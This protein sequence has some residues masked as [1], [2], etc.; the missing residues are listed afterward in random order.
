MNAIKDMY[1][2]DMTSEVKAN[3]PNLSLVKSDEAKKD[4]QLIDGRWI[5][6]EELN[7][8][9]AYFYENGGPVMDI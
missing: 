3:K 2:K 6:K 5:S 1:K 4:Y 8:K 7:E 9:L